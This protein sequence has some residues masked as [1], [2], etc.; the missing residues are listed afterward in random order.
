MRPSLLA[1]LAALFLA[2]PAL[3]Q[4]IPPKIWD[5]PFGT[6]IDSLGADFVEPACGTDGGP[7]STQLQSFADF[8]QCTPEASGLREIW[9]RYDDTIEYLARA[10]R[11]PVQAIRFNFTKV[12]MQPAILSFLVDD[13]GRIRGYR[14]HTDPAA[15]PRQRYDHRTASPLL[16]GV[17]GVEGWSCEDLPRAE[18]EGP[19]ESTYI[20]QRCGFSD[21]EV[22]A[23]NETRFYLKPGQA[24]VDPASGRPMLNAFES[25]AAITVTQNAPYPADT[26][27][28]SAEPTPEPAADDTVGRF[29]AGLSNDCVGCDLSG[30][31]LRR[32]NLTGADLT[33]A[34]LVATNLHRAVLRQ[35]KLA[36]ANLER[37]DLNLTDLTQTDFT[38]AD[39][40]Q[41]TMFG[42]RGAQT[43]FSGANLAAVRAGSI[44]IR[45]ANFTGATMTTADFGQARL[46]NAKLGGADLTGSYFF[47]ASLVRADLSKVTA[48][49]SAFNEAILRQANLAGTVFRDADFQAAD[50]READLTDADF[51]HVRFDKGNLRD[52]IQTG[53]IF[54]GSLMPD[55]TTAP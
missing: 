30:A 39:L 9:F 54:T 34:T 18:G 44:E 37:A 20:K 12:G 32:R 45:Q 2:T 4:D 50:L 49:G 33:G 35:A 43:D 47:Q 3:A 21:A 53:T 7:P 13:A 14:A 17:L 38:G 52:S 31:D 8:A 48:P 10:V 19:I 28:A 15:D 16:R 26:G 46:N 40:H 24:V 27:V 23:V 36:G 5:V 42:A 29:L 55:G 6:P 25:A 51:T 41:V 1:A 22:S 11:N